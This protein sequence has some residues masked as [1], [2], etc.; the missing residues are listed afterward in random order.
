[1]KY[2]GVEN[3]RMAIQRSTVDA[4]KESVAR[5]EKARHVHPDALV[6][7]RTQSVGSR[8][9]G[10]VA[11]AAGSW[12]FIIAYILF[13]LVYTLGN[14]A[15]IFHFDPYPFQ[16]YTFLVSVLAIL[17]AQIILLFQ[18]QQADIETRIAH[19]AYHQVAEINEIQKTQLEILEK[20]QTMTTEM[21]DLRTTVDRHG[22]GAE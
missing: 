13:T 20:L 19:N 7:A 12:S 4:P 6:R 21:H 2:E 16:F 18:N 10:W 14:K 22:D 15:G 8:A 11:S 1:V 9:A 17:L 5:T 3:E